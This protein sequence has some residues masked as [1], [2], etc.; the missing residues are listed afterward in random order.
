MP[1]LTTAIIQKIPYIQSELHLLRIINHSIAT[2]IGLPLSGLVF[3]LIIKQSPENIRSYTKILAMSAIVDTY[4]I[5]SSFLLQA[6][7]LKAK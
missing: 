4:L 2:L 7:S 6:V 1:D 5:V 3:Y